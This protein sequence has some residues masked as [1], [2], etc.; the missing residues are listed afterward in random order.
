MSA[1][2]ADT[3]NAGPSSS[4]QRP[5]SRRQ[6]ARG[7]AGVGAAALVGDG[8]RAQ[9]PGAGARRI[10][11]HH[12]YGPPPAL[13]A[14]LKKLRPDRLA[15]IWD[16]WTPAM[17]A[18]A[19]ERSG[20]TTSL[21][22]ITGPGVW[23]GEQEKE[24][25]REVTR[26]WNEYGAKLVA[27]HPGRYGLLAALPVPDVEGS[28]REIEYALETLKADGFCMLTNYGDKWLGDPA[29]APVFQELN[30]R[31]AVIYTH[32]T[33]ADCCESLVP[34]VGATMIEYGTDT[35]RAIVSLMVN[36]PSTRLPDLKIIFSHAGG[37]M[38]FLIGRIAGRKELTQRLAAPA[39]PGSRLAELRRFYYD[40]AQTAY[41]LPM[42]ALKQVV[43]VSQI[44]FGSDYPFSDMVSDV[45]GLDEASVFNAAERRAVDWENALG[46]FPRLRG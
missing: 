38:P 26:E 4:L 46:L 2:D 20:V 5:I 12:H 37:T 17:S 1:G 14:R 43:G 22:S 10:D 31:K 28:L 33:A 15:P 35:T 23:F 42:T 19:M 41:A 6:F 27:D 25:G 24:I 16:K 11:V 18:E 40:T 29:Y 30:R 39:E 44:V 21:L 36:G 9:A 3:K 7:L 13:K 32:P 34:N 45:K 8:L